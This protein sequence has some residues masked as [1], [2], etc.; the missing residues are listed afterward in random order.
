M[1]SKKGALEAT[2]STWTMFRSKLSAGHAS[3]ILRNHRS[4]AL[5][6]FRDLSNANVAGIATAVELA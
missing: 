6:D 5:R 2:V 1:Q 4:F 3:L